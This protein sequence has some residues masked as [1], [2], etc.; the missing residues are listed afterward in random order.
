MTE[1][2]N[3]KHRHFSWTDEEIDLLAEIPLALTV[4]NI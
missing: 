3:P 2:Q 4:L 1:I